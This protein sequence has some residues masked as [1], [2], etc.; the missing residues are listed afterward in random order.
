ML[1]FKNL[2][3]RI[4]LFAF[5]IV[6][7]M[8][9]RSTSMTDNLQN[10]ISRIKKK[11]QAA[12]KWLVENYQQKAF[13]LAFRILCNEDE[14]QDVVQESFIK[15]WRKIET[16][17]EKS[18]FISWL[19]K[20]VANNAIDR[21]RAKKRRNTFS[22]D[23][24]TDVSGNFQSDNWDNEMDNKEMGGLINR[25]AGSLPGKQSLV[26]ILR[27]IQGLSSEETEEILSLSQESVKSN[28]YH[29]RLAIRNKLLK[30]T[31]NERS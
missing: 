7:L 15:I 22:I 10:I 8:K 6:V 21:L 4:L 1:T 28:L 12:F 29:A 9:K 19:F 3:I 2:F 31:S 11:D 27:D 24:L 13:S 14:A 17:N 5:F 23:L 16:Y 20:I 30:T 25:L 18:A 26:F